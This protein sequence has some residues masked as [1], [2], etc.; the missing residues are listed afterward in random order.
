MKYLAETTMPRILHQQLSAR[1][2]ETVRKPGL[3]LDGHGLYLIVSESNSQLRPRP[4]SL[5]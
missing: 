3:H 1:F 4:K 2:V 5:S